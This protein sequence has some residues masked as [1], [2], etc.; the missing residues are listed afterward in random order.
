[1]EAE[2]LRKIASS[3]A[4][5]AIQAEVDFSSRLDACLKEER[6]QAAVD[7]QEMLSQI[8]N[9]INKSSERQESRWES[10]INEIRNDIQVSSS[11]FQDADDRYNAS[12]DVWAGK[13]NKL[14]E[15][16]LKSRE[17]VKSKMKQD[18]TV[19]FLYSVKNFT[20][21]FSRLSTSITPRSRQPQNPSMRKPFASWT[22]R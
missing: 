15:E 19:R 4:K 17:T 2:K 3:A 1:M 14:V 10:K 22:P 21:I 12:M 8:T 9:L 6:S 7:R 18:W 11:T 13:E 5:V 20:N 16:V